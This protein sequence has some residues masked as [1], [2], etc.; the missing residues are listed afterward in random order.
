M[1]TR[2]SS[3][4]VSQIAKTL[5]DASI[6]NEHN[7]SEGHKITLEE[8]ASVCMVIITFTER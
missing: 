7:F 5:K 1:F 2:G 8:A 6:V 4:T 3:N